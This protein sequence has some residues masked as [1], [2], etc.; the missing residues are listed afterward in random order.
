MTYRLIKFLLRRVTLTEWQACV[1]RLLIHNQ[2]ESAIWR[3]F[4]KSKRASEGQ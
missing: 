4:S 1:L 2:T 3:V